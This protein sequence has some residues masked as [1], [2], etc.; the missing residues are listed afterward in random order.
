MTGFIKSKSYRYTKHLYEKKIWEKENNK[1]LNLKKFIKKKKKKTPEQIKLVKETLIDRKKLVK[2]T[3]IDRKKLKYYAVAE[4][5]GFGVAKWFMEQPG[6]CEI[7]GK[8]LNMDYHFN[9]PT[10][11]FI[12]KEERKNSKIKFDEMPVID[13][14][15]SLGDRKMFKKNP[16]LKPR[17]LLC[18]HCNRGMG[19]LKDD[20]KLVRKTLEYL[21]K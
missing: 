5:W 16:N 14:D 6:Y 1:K 2:E 7:C 18:H 20:P 10:N 9:N 13:H 19:A 15:H 12:T 4:Y 3:L 21:E 11:P 8:K 17:G